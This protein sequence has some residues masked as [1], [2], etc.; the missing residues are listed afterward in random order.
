MVHYVVRNAFLPYSTEICNLRQCPHFSFPFAQSFETTRLLRVPMLVGVDQRPVTPLLR[1]P[2]LQTTQHGG[3][4][5]KTPLQPRGLHKSN[6]QKRGLCTWHGATRDIHTSWI[7]SLH[8]SDIPDQLRGL[9]SFMSTMVGRHFDPL[10]DGSSRRLSGLPL[11][12]D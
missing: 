6:Q 3:Q 4:D 1:C 7:L 9:F 12:M 10:R 5:I 8:W 11:S 2:F